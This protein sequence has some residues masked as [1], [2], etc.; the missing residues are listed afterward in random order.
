MEKSTFDAAETG[1]ELG[2]LYEVMTFTDNKIG[3]IVV[4]V[5]VDDFRDDLQP[6]FLAQTVLML[7]NGQRIDV[8]AP[9]ESKNLKDAKLEFP[10]AI[11]AAKLDVESQLVRHNL[12]GATKQ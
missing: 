8:K 4:M 11:A 3:S 7:P 12:A 9:L 5:P 1:P 6:I 2:D 10:Q